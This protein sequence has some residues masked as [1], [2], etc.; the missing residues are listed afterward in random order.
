[1]DVSKLFRIGDVAKLFGLSAGTLRHYEAIGL[2]KPEYTDPQSGYRYYSTRQFEALN[3]VRYLRALG[4]PLDEI[5]DFVRNRD[6]GSI[7][8]KLRAQKTAVIERERE[9]RRIERKIDNRLRQLRDAQSALLDAVTLIS[10]PPCRLVSV[11][12]TLK[13]R[14][15]L[16]L[17]TS[18]RE[19]ERAQ[20][21]AV[22]FLGK[23]GVGIAPAHLASGRFDRYDSVFLVLDEE[24]RFDGE[25]MSVPA[26]LCACIRFQGSHGEAPVQY[27][28]LLAYIRAHDLEIAGFSREITLIDY[29]L[30]N[31]PAKFVTE[32]SIPVEVSKKNCKKCQ[33]IG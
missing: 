32:I 18:I 24:D 15:S 13:V 17:E 8:D 2:V 7:E 27:E 11:D 5:A 16:D 23:V 20:A 30:T 22:V 28:K 21:E 6:I 26:A 14:G 31:D 9:L 4:M 33:N 1:M 12:G 3:T 19:L 25:V 29:G 10:V